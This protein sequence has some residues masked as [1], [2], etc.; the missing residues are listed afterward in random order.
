MKDDIKVSSAKK[1]AVRLTAAVIIAAVLAFAYYSADDVKAPSADSSAGE[2]VSSSAEVS[3]VSPE[4]DSS[5]QDISSVT[6][7]SA[8]SSL[9]DDSSSL[10]E[11]PVSSEVTSSVPTA[12]VTSTTTTT[13]AV[14]SVPVTQPPASVTSEV[15]PRSKTVS[16]VISCSTVFDNKDKLRAGV[17][18]ILPKDGIIFPRTDVT[19]NEGDTVF[20]VLKRVCKENGIHIETTKIAATNSYYIEGIAN[21]YEFDAGNLSGWMYSVNG[22]FPQTSTSNY[23]LS[24]GEKVE[25][26]YSCD[27]GVDV[28]DDYFKK[29]G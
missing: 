1:I 3:S 2:T 15:V 23:K 10:P 18:D 28:G 24:G 29:A 12:S 21:L 13:S 17:I 27:I 26:L 14:T 5:S 4:P 25:I 9:P 22:K 16:F 20:D 7:D 6:A 19:V 11:Q 8:P